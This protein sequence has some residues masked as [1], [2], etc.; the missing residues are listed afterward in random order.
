MG[1]IG[2]VARDSS[3]TLIGFYNEVIEGI[4]NPTDVEIIAA[5]RA[6]EWSLEQGFATVQV[7]GDDALN[8][9]NSIKHVETDM[10]VL[11]NLIQAKTVKGLFTECKLLYTRREGNKVAHAIAR[12]SNSFYG[13]LSFQNVNNLVAKDCS[14]IFN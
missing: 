5:T 12:E 3:G 7:E 13:C 14:I 6:M 4:N 9:I 10:C 2:A 11:G 1:G 8:V